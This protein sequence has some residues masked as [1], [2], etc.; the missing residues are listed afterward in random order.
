MSSDS[1]SYSFLSL[2]L[3][4]VA[5]VFIMRKKRTNGFSCFGPLPDET[6]GYIAKW[7]YPEHSLHPENSRC[8]C[9]SYSCPLLNLFLAPMITF[10][11]KMYLLVLVVLVQ[12]KKDMQILHQG[13]LVVST[14]SAS[15]TGHPVP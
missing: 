10:K 8:H 13:G 6:F 5:I 11:L 9:S 12:W 4:L 1:S 15:S 14:C 7:P 2:N 3:F